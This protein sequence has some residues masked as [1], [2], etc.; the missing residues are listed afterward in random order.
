[1]KKVQIVPTVLTRIVVAKYNSTR[2]IFSHVKKAINPISSHIVL[3]T[4]EKCNQSLSRAESL[5]QS[6]QSTQM[7]LEKHGLDISAH[8]KFVFQKHGFGFLFYSSGFII[9]RCFYRDKLEQGGRFNSS[10][11]NA[12]QQ[13]LNLS[14]HSVTCCHEFEL[15]LIRG[16]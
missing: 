14:L 3:F 4:C 11:K 13:S 6:E 10:M 7:A 5:S 1:M 8:L 9:N 2:A 15:T 16:K 12:S